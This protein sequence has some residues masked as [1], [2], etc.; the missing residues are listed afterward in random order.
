MSILKTLRK[1]VFG[2]TWVLPIGVALAL[3]GAELLRRALGGEWHSVGGFVL[4]AAIGALV[5]VSVRRTAT[6][7]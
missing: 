5:V 1:L 7:G 4:L 6:R 2:E 3:G